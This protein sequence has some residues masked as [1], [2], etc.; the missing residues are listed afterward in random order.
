MPQPTPGGHGSIASWVPA[1]AGMTSRQWHQRAPSTGSPRHFDAGSASP[2]AKPQWGF[3]RREGHET[4]KDQESVQWT[5][6]P[7]KARMARGPSCDATTNTWWLRNHLKLGAGLRRHGI[8]C[9]AEFLHF[10]RVAPVSAAPHT[11]SPHRIHAPVSRGMTTSPPA[12]LPFRICSSLCSGRV[13]LPRSRLKPGISVRLPPM[14][15]SVRRPRALPIQP[16][17]SPG[18]RAK[19]LWRFRVLHQSPPVRTMR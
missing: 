18:H 3:A 11:Q 5:D 17:R 16:A 13:F 10:H 14:S 2:N 12:R 6:S 9:G 7:Q 4:S 1:S 8:A 15:P 19:S